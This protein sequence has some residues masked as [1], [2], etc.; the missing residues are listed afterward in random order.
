MWKH[1]LELIEDNEIEE[2]TVVGITSG[3]FG[4]ETEIKQS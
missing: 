2:N 1:Y 3:I 4:N